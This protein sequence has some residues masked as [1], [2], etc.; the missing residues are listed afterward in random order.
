M[1][2]PVQQFFFRTA[3]LCL[4]RYFIALITFLVVF[5]VVSLIC[6]SSFTK[7]AVNLSSST[8]E[9]IKIYFAT[10]KGNVGFTES[11]TKTTRER[12]G[13]DLTRIS[14]RLRNVP[15]QDLRVDPGTGPGE[16]TSL[17]YQSGQI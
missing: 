14:F 3:S 9:P 5:K 1:I 17:K 4:N 6:L 11:Y 12:P 10:G 8:S 15:I 13:P 16:T 7:V 2:T